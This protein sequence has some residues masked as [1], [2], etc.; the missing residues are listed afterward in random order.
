MQ[1]RSVSSGEIHVNSSEIR[2]LEI[3]EGKPSSCRRFV[4]VPVNCGFWNCGRANSGSEELSIL[5][6]VVLCP[7]MSL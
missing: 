1:E 5:S 4:F 2:S 6:R 3:D 7:L